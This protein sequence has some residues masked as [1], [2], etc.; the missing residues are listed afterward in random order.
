MG[1]H[2]GCGSLRGH[3]GTLN[4]EEGAKSP[5]FFT[6]SE[7]RASIYRLVA[8]ELAQDQSSINPGDYSLLYRGLHMVLEV[9]YNIYMASK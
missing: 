8:L 2:G 4:T 6:L 3:L 7:D 5:L 1:Y 9:L